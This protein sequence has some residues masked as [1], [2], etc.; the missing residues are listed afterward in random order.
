MSSFQLSID[1]EEM[2]TSPPLSPFSSPL[3][4]PFSS[5]LSSPLLSPRMNNKR[6]TPIQ[7]LP[8]PSSHRPRNVKANS[9]FT[10]SPSKS[11][12]DDEIFAF[13]RELTFYFNA[14][15]RSIIPLDSE[16]CSMMF[17]ETRKFL[18]WCHA[19]KNRPLM[20][21]YEFNRE[22]SVLRDLYRNSTVLQNSIPPPL[23]SNRP[24]RTTSAPTQSA[25]DESIPSYNYNSP[26]RAVTSCA[27]GGNE[28]NTP[29]TPVTPCHVPA[30]SVTCP[31]PTS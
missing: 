11:W 26:S 28:A 2:L 14:A 23:H 20:S 27:G 22:F 5:P 25:C 10:L 19:N 13:M 21:S 29:P 31:R 12:T 9:E 17:T 24:V 1:E 16:K 8:T 30:V 4:S 7:T 18:D 6:P 3:S 15:E